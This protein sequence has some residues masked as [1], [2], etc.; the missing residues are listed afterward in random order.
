MNDALAGAFAEALGASARCGEH[1]PGARDSEREE[2]A[3]RG[4]RLAQGAALAGEA[5]AA[6]AAARHTPAPFAST[7]NLEPE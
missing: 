1:A 6:V 2:G 3:E 7:R 5:R 4:G